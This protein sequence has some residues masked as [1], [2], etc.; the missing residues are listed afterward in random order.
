[1]S[2]KLL[3]NPSEIEYGYVALT[4]LDRADECPVEPARRGQFR[5]RQPP[6]GSQL[7]DAESHGSEE[8]TVVEVHA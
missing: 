4:P 1:L 3:R 7:A 2:A 8:L 5:L 6:R